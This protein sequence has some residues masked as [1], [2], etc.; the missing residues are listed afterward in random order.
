MKKL[1]N[2]FLM[3]GLLFLPACSAIVGPRP[4]QESEWPFGDKNHVTI[5][6]NDFEKMGKNATNPENK[7]EIYNDTP[8]DRYEILDIDGIQKGNIWFK[9]SDNNYIGYAFSIPQTDVQ[10]KNHPPQGEDLTHAIY[11]R[12]QMFKE[13]GKTKI[14][15]EAL[16]CDE[17]T[18]QKSHNCEFKSEGETWNAVFDAPKPLDKNAIVDFELEEK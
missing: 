8:F 14:I 4:T 1:N 16:Q 15:M 6:S 9:K 5:K 18:K 10:R 11:S 13:N 7:I 3:L 2:K 12:A 17:K